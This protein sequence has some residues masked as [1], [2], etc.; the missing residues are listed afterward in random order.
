TAVY[1]AA[2]TSPDIAEP[3]P[4][5]LRTAWSVLALVDQDRPDALTGLLRHPY[6]R[7]WAVHCLERLRAA[8]GP[9]AAGRT[10]DA[11]GLAADLGHLG[12]IA[13]AAAARSRLGAAVTVPIMADAVHLPTLGRLVLGPEPGQS[14]PEPGRGG[15]GDAA[16]TAAVSVISNAVIIRAGDSCWTLSLP[17]LLAGQTDA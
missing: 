17:G 1:Q 11:P 3:V 6:L 12:A 10:Q 8:G 9:G 14:Q 15:T 2:I 16:G 4:A 5:R 7:A 13:A